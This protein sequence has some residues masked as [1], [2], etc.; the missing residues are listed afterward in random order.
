MS[1][2]SGPR[3][4][5]LAVVQGPLVKVVELAG[6]GGVPGAVVTVEGVSA[7]VPLEWLIPVPLHTE[8]GAA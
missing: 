4:G 1:D 3:I 5:E 7:W 8:D 6:R 2:Y